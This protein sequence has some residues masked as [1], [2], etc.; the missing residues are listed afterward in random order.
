M[1][2]ETL[3]GHF[4]NH[5]ISILALNTP[6]T[7][8]QQSTCIKP[9]IDRDNVPLPGSRQIVTFKVFVGFWIFPLSV[10]FS[11]SPCPIFYGKKNIGHFLWL[12]NG[13]WGL[14]TALTV[15]HL[16]TRAKPSVKGSSVPPVPGRMPAGR[17]H[18]QAECLC[19]LCLCLVLT[20]V[21]N[22]H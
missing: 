21:F 1:G 10:F 15:E 3:Q 14:W 13:C 22:L 2:G 7:T 19:V 9:L 5:L 16:A 11:P 20:F 4:R 8:T 12:K 17:M 18:Q 6:Q